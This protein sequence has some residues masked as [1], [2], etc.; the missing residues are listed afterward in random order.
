ML[1]TVADWQHWWIDLWVAHPILWLIAA[2]TGV[3]LWVGAMIVQYR[4]RRHR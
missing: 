1:Q 3:G 2:I 4:F